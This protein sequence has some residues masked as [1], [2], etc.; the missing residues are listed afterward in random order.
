[1]KNFFWTLLGIVF[2]TCLA[3]QARAVDYSE[4]SIDLDHD[5]I[6]SGSLIL[7]KME[8]KISVVVIVSGSGPT[9]RNGNVVGARSDCLKQL[10]QQLGALGV[11]SIRYDKRGVGNSASAKIHESDMRFETYVDDAAAWI[12]KLKADSR[13][14]RI[15]IAGHSEGALIA[16]L[17]AQL[18]AADAVISIE[19]VSKPADEVLITQLADKLP[20]NL[21]NENETIL[22]ALKKGKL[23]ET[24]PPELSGLY[25]QSAQPYLIS[26]FKYDPVQEMKKLRVP[27]LVLQGDHDIQVPK[28]A[29]EE[30]E[31]A[32]N[33]WI[34]Y[35]I[36]SM[37]HVLKIVTGDMGSQLSSYNDPM[38]PISEV[39][40]KYIADFLK[41]L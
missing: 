13:F 12:Q 17:A 22:A 21:L 39:L 24:V 11:A 41:S 7:P 31:K 33:R 16:V 14:S 26:W 4:T 10:A 37:N 2:I 40:P 18:G 23:V 9:D 32:T 20:K 25:R 8:G 15:A 27:V 6:I 3:G 30:L 19:G 34:I 5:G 28:D 36:P 29:A 1:M 38:S 35:V